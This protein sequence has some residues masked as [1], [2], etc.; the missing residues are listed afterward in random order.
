VAEEDFLDEMLKRRLSLDDEA[1]PLDPAAIKAYP[2]LFQGLTCT[3]AGN[4][5]I[6]E[7]W[8]VSVKSGAGCW[9]ATVRD[10]TLKYTLKVSSE[11]LDGLWAALEAE[12]AKPK[13]AWDPMRGKQPVLR[14]RRDP[15]G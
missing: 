3:D 4:G 7:T 10:D 9:N 11:T 12:L 2:R 13:P 6:R 1:A 5:Y 14:K 15:R 8:T